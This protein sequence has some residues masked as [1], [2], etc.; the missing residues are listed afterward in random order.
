LDKKN[1]QY[2]DD[3]L[4]TVKYEKNIFANILLYIIGIGIIMFFIFIYYAQ[5]DE[6]VKGLGKVIPKTR[7][8]NI[9]S[10][11]SGV[12]DKV[13]KFEGDEVKKGDKLIKLN[14][15][16]NLSKNKKSVIELNINQAK[17]VR[18]LK[19][20]NYI[21][22][23]N[24]SFA[25]DDNLSKYKSIEIDIF[26]KRVISLNEKI[27]GL[28]YK[29]AQKL[30]KIKNFNI[31]ITQLEKSEQL[32]NKEIKINKELYEAKAISIATTYRLQRELNSMVLSINSY[33]EDIVEFNN[34][35]NEIE[36]KI[37]ESLSLFRLRATQEL[38]KA[39][40]SIESLQATLMGQNDRLKRRTLLSPVNGIIKNLYFSH[41]DEVVRSAEVIEDILPTDDELLIEVKITPKDIAF[42]AIDQHAMVN[43]TAYDFSIYGGLEGKIIE[44][45][46]DSVF[47]KMRG[48]YDYIIK[49]LTKRN[50]LLGATGNKLK[51]IPGMVAEVNVLTGKKSI[52][53]FIFK[54]ILK[55]IKNSF[56][57]R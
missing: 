55:T 46:V 1:L 26:N 43:I 42:M 30:S 52:F 2:S 48:K 16:D 37:K 10:L 6:R 29:K 17:Q 28:K 57:E 9:Q 14:P 49:V 27:D 15:I 38:S 18:L 35:I 34:A 25:F 5:I 12:I 22:D 44:I 19:E 54:P 32:L 8:V 51:I 50:Y 31:K 39:N 41:K 56:H 13:Y 23:S 40:G 36:L 3:I 21:L 24:I 20:Q 53:D 45:G 4:F 11:Y 7:V 33:K 47:D